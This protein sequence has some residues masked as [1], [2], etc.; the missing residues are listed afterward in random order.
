MMMVDPACAG[1]LTVNGFATEF[2]V[3]SLRKIEKSYNLG[4]S[5]ARK[6]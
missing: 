3:E 4:L 6:L 5:L 1:R 2:M